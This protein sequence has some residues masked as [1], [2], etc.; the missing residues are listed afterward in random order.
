MATCCH[1]SDQTKDNTTKHVDNGHESDD[2][3]EKYL[4][5]TLKDLL[6]DY[7]KDLY[8]FIKTHYG[9]NYDAVEDGSGSDDTEDEQEVVTTVAEDNKYTSFEEC[10]AWWKDSR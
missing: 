9:D 6:Y 2:H 3:E 10:R 4:L 1:A 7:T 5:V 8:T